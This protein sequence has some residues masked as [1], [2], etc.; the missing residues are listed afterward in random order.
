VGISDT[1]RRMRV[2]Y[3]WGERPEGLV[4]VLRSEDAGEARVTLAGASP[5]GDLVGELLS[6]LQAK[7]VVDDD[8]LDQLRQRRH[9]AR[10]VENVDGWSL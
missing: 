7:G 9:A 10:R 3:V 1:P 6:L 8:D 2:S 4:V 5:P